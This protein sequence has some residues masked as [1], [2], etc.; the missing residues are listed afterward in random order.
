[1]NDRTICYVGWNDDCDHLHGFIDHRDS[2]IIE[3]FSE[4]ELQTLIQQGE[5]QG[6]STDDYRALLGK[7]RQWHVGLH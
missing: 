4:Q 6:K 2:H 5:A 3:E 7:I 1:M